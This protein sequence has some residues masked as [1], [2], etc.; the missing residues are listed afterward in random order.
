MKDELRKKMGA[1]LKLERE[2]LAINRD[3]LAEQL[4]IPASNLEQI[5]KGTSEGLPSDIYFELFAKS[6][7][8][9]IGIDYAA[10]SE[11]MK[12]EINMA[13]VQEET[14]TEKSGSG[15]KKAAAKKQD[16]EE[17]EQIE[18]DAG[19]S[20]L[21]KLGILLGAVVGLL[22]VFIVVYKLFLSTGQGHTEPEATTGQVKTESRTAVDNRAEFANYDWK[23]PAYQPPK[24]LVL[25]VHAYD[26]SWATILADG[27]TVIFRGLGAGR[28]YIVR[29][30]YR[31]QVSIA[32]PRFVETQLN[33]KVVDLRD[34]QTRRISR[35]IID[36]LTAKQFLKTEPPPVQTN[37]APPQSQPTTEP[38]VESRPADTIDRIPESGAETTGT[39]VSDSSKT[40]NKETG[41]EP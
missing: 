27:D 13:A 28:T 40:S 20:L 36:Q 31:I 17:Q 4:K 24:P 16:D 22:I 37:P 9:A 11:A 8:E 3:E 2:R 26:A 5:E 34:P 15:K 25:K 41:I 18:E 39:T 12:D 1:L 38:A 32:L 14:R 29:A 21:K 6:Y 33:G 19:L 35:V 30:N 10:T 7:A 23:V